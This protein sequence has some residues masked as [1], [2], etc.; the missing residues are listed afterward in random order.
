MWLFPDA[1]LIA[2][3]VTKHPGFFT[4]DMK[5]PLIEIRVEVDGTPGAAM[6]GLGPDFDR[7]VAVGYMSARQVVGSTASPHAP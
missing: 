7:V 5:C 1:R 2:V 4:A 3:N 6:A